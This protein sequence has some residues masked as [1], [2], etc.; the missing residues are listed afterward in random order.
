MRIT[1]LN[2]RMFVKK[3]DLSDDNYYMNVA[4]FIA[5]LSDTGNPHLV[6]ASQV[7]M[8][9][10]AWD[11]SSNLQEHVDNSGVHVTWID[12][13]ED[14]T[15]AN[16]NV[17]RW[18]TLANTNAILKIEVYVNGRKMIKGIDFAL[19][20]LNLPASQ[21]HFED[22]TFPVGDTDVNIEVVYRMNP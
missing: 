9:S 8:V 15:A 10:P 17:G 13:N 14:Y 7:S 11:P 1:Q 16:V 12:K 6:I 21:V 18:L 19:S 3:K 4:A 2:D 20:G 5:H 22:T